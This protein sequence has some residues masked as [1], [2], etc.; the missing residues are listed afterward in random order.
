MLESKSRCNLRTARRLALAAQAFVGEKEVEKA[1]QT[2]EAYRAFL[3]TVNAPKQA[4]SQVDDL[5]RE[6]G[7]DKPAAKRKGA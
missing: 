5:A 1:Q 7:I 6:L 2:I 4:H 3:R